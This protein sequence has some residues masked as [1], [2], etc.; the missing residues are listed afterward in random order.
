[1]FRRG[2]TR[3]PRDRRGGGPGYLASWA[4][5]ASYVHAISDLHADAHS[6]HGTDANASPDPYGDS[7]A[8][9]CAHISTDLHPCTHIYTYV[10]SAEANVPAADSDSHDSPYSYTH[11]TAPC[12]IARRNPSVTMV[13][14]FHRDVSHVAHY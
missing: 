7:N 9:F 12:S 6:Y 4:Y 10:A 13:Q 8:D 11:H 14:E 1:L 3:C 2:L 5:L